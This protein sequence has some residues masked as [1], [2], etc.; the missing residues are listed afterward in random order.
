MQNPGYRVRKTKKLL[1]DALM[2]LLAKKPLRS[3]SVKELCLL[4][5]LNRGTFYAHYADVYDLM[6]QIEDEMAA[7][8]RAAIRSS[9]S[10]EQLTPPKATKEVFKCIE[11]NADLCRVIIGPYGDREFAW[12]LIFEHKAAIIQSCR[13]YFPHADEQQFNIYYT[14]ITGGCFALMERW[15]LGGMVESSEMLADAAEKIMETGVGY[16]M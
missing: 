1:R 3:I 2:T 9:L 6:K 12:N 5:G 10:A 11:A 13:Q 8:F 16:L 14:F 7:D 4:A 15:L